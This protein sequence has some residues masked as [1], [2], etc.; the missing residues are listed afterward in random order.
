[1]SGIAYKGQRESVTVYLPVG[2]RPRRGL[3][4]HILKKGE[5]LECSKEQAEALI[6][7]DSDD[8]EGGVGSQ[9]QYVSDTKAAKK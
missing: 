6:K 7:L 5:V 3:K 1:M 9:F 4:K 8:T 2:S